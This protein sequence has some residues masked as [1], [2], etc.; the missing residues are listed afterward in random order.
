MKKIWILVVLLAVTAAA[1]SLPF[2]GRDGGLLGPTSTPT[3]PPTAT[4]E[5]TATP[6]PTPVP[7]V[8]IQKADQALFAGDFDAARL[9]YE[10][11][12][13]GSNDA[14]VRAAALNGLGK[15]QMLSGDLD[16]AVQTF[17]QVSNEFKDTPSAAT[18]FFLLGEVF[19]RKELP[20]RAAEA[21]ANY[22]TLRP[23]RIDAYA[24]AKL[25]DARFATGDY[26][27]ALQAYQAAAAAPQLDD[28]IW[29]EIN[30]G[31]TYAAMNDTTNALRNYLGIYEKT[32]NDYVKAQV[33]LLSGQVYA[34]MG[35]PEQAYARYQDSVA[36]YPMAYD[37]YSALVALIEAGQPVGELNRGLTD[38]FAGQYGVAV[39]AFNRYL[40]VSPEHDGAPHHYKALSL[41]E[42]GDYAAAQAEWDALIKDHPG[43]RWFTTAFKEKAY[44]QWAYREEYPQAAQTLLDFV[45]RFPE[46]SESPDFLFDAARILER[47][48]RLT[49]AANTWERLI[50]EYPTYTESYR[51]LFL[52]GITRYRMASYEAALLTF[53]RALVLN[54]S[55]GEQA[56][57]LLWMGKS[58]QMLGQNDKARE[59][60]NQ[61]AAADPTGY[62]S[63]RSR[64]LLSNEAPFQLEF[65]VSLDAN[66]EQE[67][68][69]AELWLR[70]NFSLPEDIN[71]Q[72]LGELN[73]DPRLIRGDE[74][75]QLGL[76][77][78]ATREFEALRKDIQENPAAT[79]RLMNHLLERGL[80]RPAVFASRQI[81]T[82]AG[83][84]DAGT[85]TAPNY[86][87][88]IRFGTYFKEPVLTAAAEEGFEPLFLFSV[89]RQESL[90]EPY[91]VSS[92]GARGL[93]QI[94]PA[95]GEEIASS[96]NWPPA[97]E[98]DDLN[99]AVINIR[100]GARYL[101]RQRD[102][103]NGDYYSM[104]AAYNAGPGN[105]QYWRELAPKDTDLFL[106]VIR[107]EETRRYIMHIAEFMNLYRRLYEIRP[108]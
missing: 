80:Y 76:Y 88:H 100:M 21:Y 46:A 93:M 41:R 34:G 107:Y 53:Q 60:W 90:F 78:Q 51:A 68:R 74:F 59:S 42:L 70:T 37:S 5:P 40:A 87:N 32:T 61:A 8:R 72:D 10:T 75:W 7:E 89:L 49:E 44:T 35:M 106:E 12:L 58:Y 25:G 103:F 95:T 13:G 16:G 24:Q 11:A 91:V 20:E 14:G 6:T 38:Y 86:F 22:L 65:P 29:M 55:T 104:L 43:D 23:G 33:N 52:S 69:L 1:C 94:M 9:E 85:F 30:V 67:R 18:A 99:R 4:P 2:L 82:L 28:P 102:Y 83:L 96:M 77:S 98:T 84:D 56:Q 57:A 26:G 50:T 81:L 48:N 31:R 62:Y 92:A 54:T 64:E 101:A 45:A 17:S 97:Y 47:A 71:L 27:M 3:T 73:S 108:Q 15:I 79:F 19:S 63:E 66:L 39:E 105:V 36:N